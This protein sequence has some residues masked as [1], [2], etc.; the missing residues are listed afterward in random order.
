MRNH[1]IRALVSSALLSMFPSVALANAA[2]LD[3]KTLPS[4]NSPGAAIPRA[5]SAESDN[6][7]RCGSQL[8][9]AETAV[10]RAVSAAGWRLFGPYQLFNGTAIVLGQSDADGMCRPEGYQGFV[11]VHGRFAGT[12]APK[13]MGARTDGSLETPQLFDGS[14]FGV[15]FARY[16]TSD[17]LCCP[18]RTTT[19]TYKIEQ[20]SGS[21][22]VVPT[23]A[24]SSKNSTSS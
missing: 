16:A 14:S 4:W 19:V 17:P 24:S 8:R 23:E 21:A 1:A 2:W 10:D 5:P 12:L 18:S 13:P 11:F 15:Q 22:I 9:H 3:A 6:L 7:S 20:R